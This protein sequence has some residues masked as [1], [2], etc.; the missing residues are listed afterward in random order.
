MN[1]RKPPTDL[2][3]QIIIVKTAQADMNTSKIDPL[4]RPARHA[5]RPGMM[6]V[7]EFLRKKMPML[8]K[9][10]ASASSPVEALR[11]E[12][13]QCRNPRLIR[14]EISEEKMQ[15]LFANR[16]LC[17]ADFHCLDKASH[18]CVREICL[19]NCLRSSPDGSVPTCR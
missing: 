19:K 18:H 17:V 7:L 14:L 5:A 12:P 3:H 8:R 15:H 11:G 16:Q 6:T 4:L 13:R 10:G 1:D 9:N 2:S